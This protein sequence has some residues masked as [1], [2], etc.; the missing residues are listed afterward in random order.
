V[1]N[2]RI[3]SGR[4][5]FFYFILFVEACDKFGRSV[6]QLSLGWTY[7]Q[8]SEFQDLNDVL[9]LGKFS[10]SKQS[11]IKELFQGTPRILMC[12]GED[13]DI[14]RHLQIIPDANLEFFI[15][16]HQKLAE[17]N[18]ILP[19]YMCLDERN[20]SPSIAG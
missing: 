20:G 7:I 12:A 10:L 2:F 5:V 17:C 14:E 19:V 13:S 6:Q 1:A 4:Y 3:C 15:M 16:R 8:L 9:E 11:N 18:D